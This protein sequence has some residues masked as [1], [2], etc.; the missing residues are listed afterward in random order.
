MRFIML[1]YDRAYLK[2]SFIY[3]F[4]YCLNKIENLYCIYI[5]QQKNNEKTYNN[6]HVYENCS[7]KMWL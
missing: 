2:V 6:K 5:K 7:E 1:F 4:I 3:F